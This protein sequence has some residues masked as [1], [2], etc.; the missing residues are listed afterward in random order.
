MLALRIFKLS[1]DFRVSI[2]CCGGRM[3]LRRSE[4]RSELRRLSAERPGHWSL[5]P[6]A[7]TPFRGSKPVATRV[8]YL[9]QYGRQ[10]LFTLHRMR[11]IEDM[12]TW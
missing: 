9:V 8:T 6:P 10:S 12:S 1:F 4:L 7:P 2:P 5:D 3:L 11:E